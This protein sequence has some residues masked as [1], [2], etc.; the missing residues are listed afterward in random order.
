MSLV[1][2]GC[3]FVLL[4]VLYRLE[5][6]HVRSEDYVCRTCLRRWVIRSNGHGVIEADRQHYA[7]V[8]QHMQACVRKRGNKR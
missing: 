8:L 6:A 3:L 7:H 5:M 4:Y 2:L 1:S